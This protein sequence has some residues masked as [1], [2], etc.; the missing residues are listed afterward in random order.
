MLRELLPVVVSGLVPI[1]VIAVIVVGTAVDLVAWQPPILH[2]TQFGTANSQ[3]G[4]TGMAFDSTGIYATGIVGLSNV[5][6]SYLFVS[7]Y[8]TDARQ[9]WTQHFG[10]ATDFSKVLGVAVGANG[11]YVVGVLDLS[12]NASF[13]RKYDFYGNLGWNV[14]FGTGSTTA[15][16]VSVAATNI[17]VGGLFLGNTAPYF[18]RSYDLNG[19][20]VWSLLLGS[21]TGI[22][23]IY[24]NSGGVFTSYA[25]S[26]S[27]SEFT[28]VVQ[29][30][31][32]Y[33]TLLWNQTC[34]CSS[35]AIAGDSSGIYL[36]GLVPTSSGI[37]D[38]FLGKYSFSG[39]ELW[40]TSFKAPG[41]DSIFTVRVSADSSGVYLSSTT[42]SNRGIVM[43]Y[44]GNGNLQWSVLL[45]WTIGFGGK[46]GDAIAVGSGEL[47][48][49]GYLRTSAGDAAFITSASESSSL[50]FFGV[51][52]PLSFGVVGFLVA[53]VAVSVLVLRRRWKSRL[54]LAS[55]TMPSRSKRIPTD[56]TVES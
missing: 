56:F 25:A 52:P 40:T 32:P 13:V 41:N 14:Q 23:S 30:Y 4:I 35:T 12:A 54:R 7:K 27:S 53:A 8:D 38:G 24:A 10:N 16:A 29:S 1:A 37:T 18:L 21:N 45:P 55:P 26:Y 22:I 11:V 50:V 20:L 44:N 47:Y 3:N 6:P 46:G 31:D 19:G 42:S 9:V 2:T 15:T 5:A 39:N 17:Y 51:T 36:V 28:S 43:K 33:G 34:S 49:G 48:V